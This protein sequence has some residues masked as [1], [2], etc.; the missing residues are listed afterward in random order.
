MESNKEKIY[1]LII[2]HGKLAEELLNSAKLIIG[3]FENVFF[4]NFLKN[5]PV[6]ELAEK[7]KDFVS[8]HN[9]GKILIFTDLFG[10]S[11]L[12]ACSNFVNFPDVHILAGINLPI[13]LETIILKNS[14][15]F[16]T[17]I[18]ILKSKI[19]QFIVDVDEKL[20]YEK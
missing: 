3:N 9:D 10:G 14:V 16:Q 8:E 13:L 5:M 11:C 1:L 6:E 15:D 19:S 18:N 20:N 2:T 12:N 7:I 4:I 17:L